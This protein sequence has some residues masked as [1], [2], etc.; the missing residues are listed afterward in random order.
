MLVND[1][2]Q[3]LEWTSFRRSP[4]VTTRIL[5]MK[6]QAYLALDKQSSF[7]RSRSRCQY[8]SCQKS[9]CKNKYPSFDER[10]MIDK[11]LYSLLILSLVF[12]MWFGSL[13]AYGGLA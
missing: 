4:S 9:H 5:G 8:I 1:V 10:S 13:A 11:Y 2:Y 3:E 6:L 7:L 12:R